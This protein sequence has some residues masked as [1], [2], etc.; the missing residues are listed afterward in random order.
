M[1]DCISVKI[2]FSLEVALGT[3]KG[4]SAVE[5]FASKAGDCSFY[6][7]LGLGDGF[8]S[9]STEDLI[10]GELVA[11]VT[12][13]GKRA[14]LVFDGVARISENFDRTV[15]PYFSNPG[16]KILVTK[17][18]VLVCKGDRITDQVDF[19]TNVDATWQVL[20]TYVGGAQGKTTVVDKRPVMGVLSI[21]W[22]QL[23]RIEND[24]LCA[25]D[26]AQ[27]AAAL[28]DFPDLLKM[29]KTGKSKV[30]GVWDLDSNV[31]SDVI[32]TQIEFGSLVMGECPALKH[33]EI[34]FRCMADVDAS[35]DE[36]GSEIMTGLM[37][38]IEKTKTR[39]VFF[40]CENLSCAIKQST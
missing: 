2:S 20:C 3:N 36:I 37:P 28:R 30:Q 15:I 27:V 38:A 10:S 21:K 34:A 11:Y 16:N 6:V 14:M 23:S 18:E 32:V 7:T 13:A 1:D 12:S 25:E 8:T 40:E 22:A 24:G 17:I 39:F 33:V 9:I 4:R 5:K 31:V 35:E 19:D 29:I 26:P